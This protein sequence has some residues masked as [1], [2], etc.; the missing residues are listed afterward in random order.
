MTAKHVLMCTVH[1]LV[2]LCDVS[3]SALGVDMV[4][5]CEVCRDIC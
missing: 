1:D 4:G 2:F 3:T 5:A